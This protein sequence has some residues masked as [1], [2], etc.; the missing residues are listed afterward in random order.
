MNTQHHKII[1]PEN[2]P[3]RKMFHSL[4]SAETKEIGKK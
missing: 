3:P 1:Q 4:E 2:K